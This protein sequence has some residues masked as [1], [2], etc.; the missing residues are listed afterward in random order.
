MASLVD[1]IRN[2]RQWQE[3]YCAMSGKPSF[4]PE[5]YAAMLEEEA[6]CLDNGEMLQ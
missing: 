3:G 1:L 6:V 4:A 5:S 2:S